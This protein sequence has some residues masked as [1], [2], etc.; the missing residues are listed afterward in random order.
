MLGAHF[1]EVSFGTAAPETA[2]VWAGLLAATA[3]GVYSAA[4]WS[5]RDS[6]RRPEPLPWYGF[7][8]IAMAAWGILMVGPLPLAGRAFVA[9]GRVLPSFVLLSI[10]RVLF[11][12]LVLVPGALLLGASLTFLLRAFVRDSAA[13]RDQGILIT[14]LAFGAA[15]GVA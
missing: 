8:Q 6:S 4:R 12:S 15:S 13:G 1:L 7:A 14:A 2:A 9:I 11:C 10:A 3:L 5:L